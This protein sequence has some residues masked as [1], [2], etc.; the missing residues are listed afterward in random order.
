MAP[1]LSKYNSPPKKKDWDGGTGILTQSEAVW[2]LVRDEFFFSS[3]PFLGYSLSHNVLIHLRG[4][5]WCWWSAQREA[6]CLY[7]NWTTWPLYAFGHIWR[8]RWLRAYS[9]S[10]V[11]GVAVLC[12]LL[13]SDFLYLSERSC[14]VAMSCLDV[15]YHQSYGAHYLPA[16]AYK[17]TY[18]N[19][20]HQ[21]QQV[22]YSSLVFFGGCGA[23][24][25]SEL[26]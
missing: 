25:G 19:H 1:A 7:A 20:H 12:A 9:P 5:G 13:S 26:E 23:W 2:K 11:S 4:P 10:E 3:S 14:S 17:A 24:F 22:R 6:H 21:Q 8:R 16:A 18:Y 15:M